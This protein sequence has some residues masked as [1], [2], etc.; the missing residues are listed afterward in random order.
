M[1]NVF[2]QI[3]T[4]NTIHDFLKS[5]GYAEFCEENYLSKV[6]DNGRWTIII[7]IDGR[8]NL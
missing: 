2:V 1:A 4:E 3:G 6:V 5:E 8:R 7:T